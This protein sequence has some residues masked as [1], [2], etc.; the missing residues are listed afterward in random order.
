MGDIRVLCLFNRNKICWSG[1][2]FD[3]MVVKTNISSFC[4]NEKFCLKVTFD[5]SP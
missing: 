3:L 1:E 4:L 5:N 2:R